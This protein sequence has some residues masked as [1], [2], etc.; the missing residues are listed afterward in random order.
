MATVAKHL[1][2]TGDSDVKMGTAP[3]FYN[4]IMSSMGEKVS[5]MVS[6]RCRPIPAINSILSHRAVVLQRHHEQRG[7]K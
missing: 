6:L 3:W 7:E 2:I 1:G 4:G 5:K